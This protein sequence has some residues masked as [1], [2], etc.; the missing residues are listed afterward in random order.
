M[1]SF[2]TAV[3]AKPFVFEQKFQKDTRF[4][5]ISPHNTYLTSNQT[6][7]QLKISLFPCRWIVN[8]VRAVNKDQVYHKYKNSRTSHDRSLFVCFFVLIQTSV[9]ELS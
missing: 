7:V 1:H 9:N 2:I 6:V 3:V 8:E 4:A 5:I